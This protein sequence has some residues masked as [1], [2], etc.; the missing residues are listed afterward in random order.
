MKIDITASRTNYKIFLN[1]GKNKTLQTGKTRYVPKSGIEITEKY[2]SRYI[3]AALRFLTTI[4]KYTFV[5]ND[6]VS[7][8]K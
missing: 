7:L 6:Q 5:S 1:T 4:M 2:N 3:Q 8:F